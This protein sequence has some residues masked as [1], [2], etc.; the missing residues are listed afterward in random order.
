MTATQST[1]NNFRKIAPGLYGTGIV[2]A[3]YGDGWDDVVMVEVA[4][5]KCDG[6]WWT[7]EVF[8]SE[9]GFEFTDYAGEGY[10]TLTEA[11]AARR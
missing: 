1:N 6:W 8:E 5:A 10:R 11:K 3:P 9:Q 2:R 7:R 4:I